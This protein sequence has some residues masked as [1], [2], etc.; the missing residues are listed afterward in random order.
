MA[1]WM[2]LHWKYSS[3]TGEVILH[4]FALLL[5]YNKPYGQSTVSSLILKIL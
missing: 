1:I 2:A 3:K 4:S 5:V